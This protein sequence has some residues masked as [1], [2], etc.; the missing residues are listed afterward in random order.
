MT[1]ETF[2]VELE[3]RLSIAIKEMIPKMVPIESSLLGTGWSNTDEIV[4]AKARFVDIQPSPVRSGQRRRA[5]SSAKRPWRPI[6]IAAAGLLIVSTLG[7]VVLAMKARDDSP[8]ASKGAD[9]PSVVTLVAPPADMSTPRANKWREMVGTALA[10]A[11]WELQLNTVYENAPVAGNPAFVTA[12]ALVGGGR[13]VIQRTPFAAGEYTNDPDWQAGVAGAT[14]HGQVTPDGTLFRVDEPGT[15]VRRVEIV[16]TYGII[17]VH[18]E[19]I[20]TQSL[21]DIAVFTTVAV[22]LA[23]SAVESAFPPATTPTLTT[24]TSAGTEL[25]A[26]GAVVCLDAGASQ[27]AVAL[28]ADELGGDPIEA[29]AVSAD[30]FVMPVDPANPSHVT[31]TARIGDLLNVPVRSLDTSLLPADTPRSGAAAT[32]YLVLGA[33]DIPYAP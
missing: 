8:V 1:F 24:V 9:V 14:S 29:A 28:C 18:A 3:Q 22:S 19:A 11:R 15:S 25:I 2:D 5:P 27:R 33:S 31:E 16:T 21:P 13:V 30:S 6:T 7:A 4:E 12:V 26:P 32:T 17:M 20:P 10:D 23:R